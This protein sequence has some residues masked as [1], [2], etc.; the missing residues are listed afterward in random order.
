[1]LLQDNWPEMQTIASDLSPFYLARARDNL[2][3]W[4]NQRAPGADLGGTDGTGAPRFLFVCFFQCV[5]C[6]LSTGMTVCLRGH[7]LT[8]LAACCVCAHACTHPHTLFQV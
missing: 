2:S 7:V 3:Y 1:M 4:R 8:C 5:V 6:S